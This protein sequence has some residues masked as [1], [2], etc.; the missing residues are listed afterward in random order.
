A[1]Y[2]TTEKELLAVVY[3]FEKF[4]PY[5]VLSNTIVY[6]NY[7][8][9]KYLLAKQDANPRLLRWILLLQEFNVIIRDKKG[10][11]NLTADHLSRLENPYQDELDKKEITETFPLETLGMIAFRGDSKKELLAVVYAFEKFRPYLV[12]SKT[13]VYTNYL[14]LKYLLAKQDAKPRLLRWIL[15]LQEFNV[16]IRDKKGTENLTANHLS[17][18]ENPHQDELG[19]KEITETFPL[20]TLGM[21]AFRGDSST[22]WFADIANYHAGNFIVKGMSSQQ[23]K[24]FFKDVNHYFWDD[25]YLFKICADQVIRR[26]VHGQEAVDILTACHNRPTMGH[27]DANFTAKKVFDFGFYWP[28]IYRDA[29][30]LVTRCD[31]CQ[32]QGDNRASWP[33]KLDNTLWAFRTTFKTPIE[34]TPYKLVYGKACHLPIE[35]EHKAYW[36][37]KHAYFILHYESAS[38]N[39]ASTV[40]TAKA[41]PRK[42]APSNLIPQQQGMNE[43]TGNTSYDHSFAGTD[44]HVLADKTKYPSFKDLDSPKDDPIIVVDDSDKDEE[45]DRVYA[46]INVKTE[47]ALSQKHKLEP[48]K[49]KAEAEAALRRAQPSFPNIEQL[50]ELLNVNLT[51]QQSKPTPPPTTPII[52]PVIKTTTTQMQYLF[53]QSLPKSSSQPEGEHIEKDKGK[54]ALS[55]KEAE[56]ESNDSDSN[57]ETHM[58][59][60]IVESSRIKKVKRFDFVI[61]AGKH[62]HLTEEQINQQKKIEEEAKAEAAKHDFVTI[63]D[64]KDFLNKM[65]C[66][67]QEI[68]FKRHQGPGLDDHARTFSSL[69]LVEIDKRNLN[70]LK[71][72]RVIEQL[73]P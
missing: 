7:L 51:K 37:L 31:A 38:K 33:D 3:A 6:T 40:S 27:Y 19:K 12:L 50:N 34:W 1:H 46:T 8:A 58:T 10:M 49:N 22:T 43:G 39:D 13:I 36:A 64:L 11:E 73:R 53:L 9:I 26:C 65:L 45:A 17:R 24:K 44:P 35:L 54:K 5:L 30:D 57:D 16:I 18:L 67:V 47:D 61:E 14:A 68:L 20:E 66:T 72:I 69:L 29:H 59:G 56:K 2:T 60:S 41:D 71:Q 23:K 28:T 63:E 48:E 15:L 52:P 42:S 70:T 4:R 55:L 21:I 25:P 62:I 32:R